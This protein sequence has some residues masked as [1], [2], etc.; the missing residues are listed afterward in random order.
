V[1]N[2]WAV[3]VATIIFETAVGAVLLLGTRRIASWASLA[4][5]AWCMGLIPAVAWPFFATLLPLTA[6]QV[7][8]F[9]RLRRTIK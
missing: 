2:A 3:V 4:G 8:L 5:A 6:L 9:V 7:W 1:P